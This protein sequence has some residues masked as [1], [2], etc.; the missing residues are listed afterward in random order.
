MKKLLMLTVALSVCGEPARAQI[1]VED[2]AQLRQ[3]LINYGVQLKQAAT[4]VQQLTTEAQQLGYAISTF[5]SLVANPNL[6]NALG[7]L[8]QLGVTDPLPVDPYTLQSLVSGY[9][10]IPGKLGVLS[11]LANSAAANNRIYQSPDGT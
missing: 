9:G 7:L 3:T 10:G 5:E 11:N 2:F 6:A 4:E 1:A 8:Q